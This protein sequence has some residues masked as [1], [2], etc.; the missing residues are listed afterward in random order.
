MAAFLHV[1]G[2]NRSLLYGHCGKKFAEPPSVVQVSLVAL[3]VSVTSLYVTEIKTIRCPFGQ[4]LAGR[5]GASVMV[6]EADPL[7]PAVTVRSPLICCDEVNLFAALGHCC[8]PFR[9]PQVEVAVVVAVIVSEAPLPSPEI[10]NCTARL[11]LR[12]TP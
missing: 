9:Q 5:A 4:K 8:P 11:P 12:L 3:L 6:P 1:N 7:W 10:R 2:L